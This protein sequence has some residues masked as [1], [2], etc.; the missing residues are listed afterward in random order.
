MNA[1]PK[2]QEQEAEHVLQ[3][4][5]TTNTAAT[6]TST[7]ATDG[8][9]ARELILRTGDHRDL[10][11]C[12]LTADCASY[13]F[14]SPAAASPQLEGSYSALFDAVPVVLEQ[15]RQTVQEGERREQ[16]GHEQEL[17]EDDRG[18][19]GDDQ[20]E[21]QGPQKE[22]HK[23]ESQ[24]VQGEAHEQEQEQEQEVQKAQEEVY[25]QELQQP[26]EVFH[27]QEMQEAQEEVREQGQEVQEAQEEVHEQQTQEEVH[28]QVGDDEQEAREARDE[29]RDQEMLQTQEQKM[30]DAHEQELQEEV[31]GH[32]AQEAQEEVREQAPGAQ[33]K[34]REQEAN[35]KQGMQEVREHEGDDEQE[36]DLAKELARK[37]AIQSMA[38]KELDRV[39][40]ALDAF[41]NQDSFQRLSPRAQQQLHFELHKEADAI[42]NNFIWLLKKEKKLPARARLSLE[43]TFEGNSHEIAS[44]FMCRNMFQLAHCTIAVATAEVIGSGDETV[45]RELSRRKDPLGERYIPT[46]GVFEFF[47]ELV[48]EMSDRRSALEDSGGE[49]RAPIRTRMAAVVVMS[50]RPERSHRITANDNTGDSPPR[51]KKRRT[52]RT[53]S[54]PAKAEPAPSPIRG[55]RSKRKR[56]RHVEN[57]GAEDGHPTSTQR[58]ELADIKA[59]ELDIEEMAQILSQKRD[60]YRRKY[61]TCPP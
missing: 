7:T 15:Q 24:G 9:D 20:R 60:A 33:E 12:S 44:S 5:T 48:R 31:H 10:D 11:L 52:A 38:D 58:R 59:I 16:E 57:G 25:G 8:T 26:Q 35:N 27:E 36:D 22:V 41:T 54:P 32:E 55:G 56:D 49:D 18:K 29:V 2:P 40:A 37:R 21:A 39:G 61:G 14:S 53:T 50:P 4:I 30:P 13:S 43:N 23:Q 3:A 34:V 47:P 51:R 46:S 28:E 19:E 45:R 42:L 1:I 17:P 6:T